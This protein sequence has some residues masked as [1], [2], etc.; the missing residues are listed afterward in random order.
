MAT[1]RTPDMV[2]TRNGKLCLDC[3][4]STGTTGNVKHVV[5]DYLLISGSRR[6]CPVGWCNKFKKA[7]GRKKRTNFNKQEFI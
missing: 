1:E 3:Y 2:S 4:Y 5:C 6:M 7:N